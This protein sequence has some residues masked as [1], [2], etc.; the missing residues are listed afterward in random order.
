MIMEVRRDLFMAVG[1]VVAVNVVIS[2]GAVGLLMRMTPVIGK[3]IEENVYSNQAVESMLA[4]LADS[5]TVGFAEERRSRFDQALELARRNITETEEIA[6]IDRIERGREK[7]LSG[8]KAAGVALVRDLLALVDIN[9]RAMGAV[10]REAQR[11]GSAGAWAAVAMAVFV[12]VISSM[13][14][15][16]LR[17]RIVQPLEE[18]QNV[19]Q[20][21]HRGDRYRRC[22]L[23]R[24]PI[25]IRRVLNGVNHLLDEYSR[26]V[27]EE[28]HAAGAPE[29][30][31]SALG[32]FLERERE[33]TIVVDSRG[34]VVAANTVGL[35]TLAQDADGAV[36]R[37]WAQLA[38]GAAQDAG[39]GEVRLSGGW[40]C[41]LRA[42]AA[43]P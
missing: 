31:R 42:P 37:R 28:H 19:L 9:R 22:Q 17:R 5:N 12:F 20:A 27:T 4:V 34:E 40:L 7:A 26:C 38:A 16:R 8:D 11:L 3:I 29:V 18:V 23:A 6:V 33:G 39:S 32:Y 24:G 36:K 21:A 1:V 14:I 10:D 35:G 13:V 2:F 41:V 25:E 30:E 43:K 15:V